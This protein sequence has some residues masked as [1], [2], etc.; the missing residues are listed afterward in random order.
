[1]IGGDLNGSGWVDIVD[2]TYYINRWGTDYG[3]G[4]TACPPSPIHA[5]ISGNGLVDTPDFLFIQTYFLYSGDGDCCGPLALGG[6][7]GPLS[8]IAV[9]GL[10]E[11]GLGHLAIADLNGDGMVDQLD[12]AAFA[13]AVRP[14]LHRVIPSQTPGFDLDSAGTK[15]MKEPDTP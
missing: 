15:R 14:P 7:D 12:V 2:F 6:G 11:L 3:T 10:I 1:M 9:D 8:A 13:E 4:D 5:D